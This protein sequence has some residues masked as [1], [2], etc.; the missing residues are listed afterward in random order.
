LEVIR[1]VPLELA[2]HPHPHP[3]Q[4]WVMEAT[5]TL[6][7]SMRQTMPGHP[8]TVHS[9]DLI[10]ILIHLP[11]VTRQVSSHHLKALTTTL[12]TCM[13]QLRMVPLIQ[14]ITAI[15]SSMQCISI[16]TLLF[17]EQHRTQD[18]IPSEEYPQ[19]SIAGKSY[20]H[21]FEASVS[22]KTEIPKT[23]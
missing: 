2:M 9:I 18:L 7:I 14:H 17:L 1:L 20:I 21:T 19:F 15:L 6:E 16:H 5:I 23:E 12:R 22:R 4:E 11:L 10:H 13:R 3:H 8:C